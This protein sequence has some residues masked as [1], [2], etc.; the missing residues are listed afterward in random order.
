MSRNKPTDPRDIK[1]VE[2]LSG[3]YSI[4]YWQAGTWLIE[5]WIFIYPK[6]K[7]WGER[8]RQV[9]GYYER[10]KLKEFVDTA[11]ENKFKKDDIFHGKQVLKESEL[12]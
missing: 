6:N 7:K 10:G 8:Y 3:H 12:I 1:E 2:Q 4:E 9:Y 11:M 5:G